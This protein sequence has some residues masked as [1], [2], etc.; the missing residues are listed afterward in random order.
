MDMYQMNFIEYR[1]YAITFEGKQI[2]TIRMDDSDGPMFHYESDD[3]T[4]K[5][6]VVEIKDA[7]RALKAWNE[8][9]DV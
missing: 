3:G 6:S 1:K 7:V 5:G 2:G 9:R 8:L 4:T